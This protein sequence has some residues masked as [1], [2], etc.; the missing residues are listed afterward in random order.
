MYLW[1]R[2]KEQFRESRQGLGM[3]V[4]FGLDLGLGHSLLSVH[5]RPVG[6]V[7]VYTEKYTDFDMK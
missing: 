1:Y 6:T 4:G 5:F 7:Q 2:W 3:G